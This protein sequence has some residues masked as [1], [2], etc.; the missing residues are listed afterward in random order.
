[1]RVSEPADM[2]PGQDCCP[3]QEPTISA[4]LRTR[5][6]N[7]GRSVVIDGTAQPA[8]LR[9]G[10]GGQVLARDHRG[11]DHDQLGGNLPAPPVGDPVE[12]G[13]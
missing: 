6:W 9:S 13:L 10:S 11:P 12:D 5:L 8:R 4:E 1:M 3:S 7:M 2:D